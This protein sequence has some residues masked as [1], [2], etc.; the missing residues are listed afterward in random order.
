[1]RS[2]VRICPAAPEK[3]RK[4]VG[5]AVFFF[6]CR[7]DSNVY[8]SRRG[9]L[10]RPV[11]K[12]VDS[13]I[14][15]SRSPARENR[16]Q[17]NTAQQLRTSSLP[18]MRSNSFPCAGGD[19][20]PLSFACPKERGKENDTQEGNCGL[21]LPVAEE[22][23][24]QFPQPRHWRAVAKQARE[25]QMRQGGEISGFCPPCGARKTVRAYAD[26]PVFRPLRK[27]R[28]PCFR[29]RRREPAIPLA[30]GSL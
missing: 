21:A 19:T 3:H 8:R 2:A 30:Q 15:F 16:M 17:T 27:F 26:P 11:R 24:P 6:C 18:R 14:L 12:L 9:R 1:M 10:H 23:R 29:H 7:A 22:A 28:A 4:P 13:L 5:P 20:I 25:W